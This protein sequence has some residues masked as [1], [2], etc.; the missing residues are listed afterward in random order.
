[1]YEI[2][3]KPIGI[4]ASTLEFR[5]FVF[6][7]QHSAATKYCGHV[8]R[9]RDFVVGHTSIEIKPS[10]ANT[11]AEGLASLCWERCPPIVNCLRVVIGEPACHIAMDICGSKTTYEIR[12]V[13]S[14]IH[15]VV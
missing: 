11:D 15:G 3:A 1:M 5:W 10:F 7:R 12:R 6:L 14:V 9:W 8:D 4:F 13:A 2:A